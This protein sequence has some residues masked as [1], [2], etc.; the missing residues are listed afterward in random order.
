MLTNDVVSLEQPD[1]VLLV[2]KGWSRCWFSVPLQSSI[3]TLIYRK[4]SKYWDMYG[5]ANSLDSDQTALK[6]R[7]VKLF[8]CSLAQ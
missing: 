8:F 6:D 7:G 4:N 5:W 2:W 3:T 1:P